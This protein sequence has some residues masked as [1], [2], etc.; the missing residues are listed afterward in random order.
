[1]IVRLARVS[2]YTLRMRS[3][4]LVVSAAL[5]SVLCSASAFALTQPLPGGVSLPSGATIKLPFE[6][7]VNVHVLSG[8]GP[9]A[10]SSLHDGLAETSKTNDYYGVDFTLPDFPNVGLGQPVLAIA[11]GQVV[12]AGWATSG[13][14]NYGQ[15]V[16]LKHDFGDGHVYHAIYCHLNAINVNEGDTVQGGQQIG[17]LGDSCD[18]DNKQLSCPW[19]GPHLHFALHQD[20]SIGGSGTGGSYAGHAV[21]PEPWDG[22]EDLKQGMD[23]VSGNATGPV[24][25]CQVIGPAGGILDDKGKCFHKLGTST[26][27]HEETLGHDGH[28]WWTN[29]TADANPDDVG[30]WD[31]NLEVATKFTV[32][33][34]AEPGFAT[35]AKARFVVRHAG[36]QDTSVVDQ[37]QGGWVL[38][39]KYDFAAGGDQWV[40]LEDNTGEALSLKLKVVSDALRF[41]PEGTV[42]ADGGAEAAVP[43]DAGPDA[44]AA[45]AS[46]DGTAGDGAVADSATV[47][48]GSSP[49]G[50]PSP[51]EEG[52]SCSTPG[53]APD[54]APWGLLL[55]V[56]ATAGVRRARQR[57]GLQGTSPRRLGG[58]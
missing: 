34:Y 28:L 57:G 38:L 20:S 4:F 36:A 37:S 17:E 7:G 53:R 3:F 29:A 5:A 15:R 18:G 22:Y 30:R 56:V 54:R 33:A 14:A 1:M 43:T 35:S 44:K 19:F 58:P 48:S 21:V 12:K 2:L 24:T 41:T 32:E 11:A 9:N 42:P 23:L 10:G 47:D 50:A 13:R 8:Y 49:K 52:C 45:D 46:P 55:L 27:W 26:Y 25:P 16:I 40:R 39:G 51:P 31:V 6:A